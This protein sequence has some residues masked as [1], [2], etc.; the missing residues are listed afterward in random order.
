V[1]ELL[2]M[3]FVFEMMHQTWCNNRFGSFFSWS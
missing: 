1:I 3:H 2:K